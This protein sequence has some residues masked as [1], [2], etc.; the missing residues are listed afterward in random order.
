M[1]LYNVSLAL[2]FSYNDQIVDKFLN[3]FEVQFDKDSQ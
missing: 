1:D 3:G 2:Q